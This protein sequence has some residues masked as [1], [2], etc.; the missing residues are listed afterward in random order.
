MIVNVFIIFKFILDFFCNF[1]IDLFL[2]VIFLIKLLRLLIGFVIGCLFVWLIIIMVLM[3][4]FWILFLI[5]L[6]SLLWIY[7]FK[8]LVSLVLFEGK[9]YFFAVVI[10]ILGGNCG[11]LVEVLVVSFLYNFELFFFLK[12]S[13]F[14]NCLILFFEYFKDIIDFWYLVL[15]FW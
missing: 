13:D 6:I 7:L 8:V 2:L 11:I 1:F 10:R 9:L 4:Y 3:L 12:F 14:V 15:I 5:F